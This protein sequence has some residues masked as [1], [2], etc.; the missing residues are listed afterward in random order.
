MRTGESEKIIL[1]IIELPEHGTK[2]QILGEGAE[3][4][5]VPRT[6][7]SVLVQFAI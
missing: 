4:K 3:R 6:F 7:L 2:K 1:E 5:E